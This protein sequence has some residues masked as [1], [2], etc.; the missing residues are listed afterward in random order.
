MLFKGHITIFAIKKILERNKYKKME[1][2]EKKYQGTYGKTFSLW[3]IVFLE[4]H[5]VEDR[6]FG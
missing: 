6:V 2:V 4:I 5:S 1:V 3:V